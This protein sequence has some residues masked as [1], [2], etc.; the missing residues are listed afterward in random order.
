MRR[1]EQTAKYGTLLKEV[2]WFQLENA[3][4][5][6]AAEEARKSR[7]SITIRTTQSL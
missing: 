2:N 3:N 5:T 6:I 7:W 4:V 1:Q